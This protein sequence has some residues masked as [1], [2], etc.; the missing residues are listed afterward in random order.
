[1]VNGSVTSDKS[2]VFEILYLYAESGEV[3][4][5][6]KRYY[7]SFMIRSSRRNY[8]QTVTISR[9]AY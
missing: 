2:L 9:D 4:L 5:V 1:M 7:I 6:S 3:R 8:T